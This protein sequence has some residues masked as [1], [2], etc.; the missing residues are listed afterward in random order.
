MKKNYDFS[1]ARLNPYVKRL[2]RQGPEG[3]GA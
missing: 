3:R 1:K 2:K